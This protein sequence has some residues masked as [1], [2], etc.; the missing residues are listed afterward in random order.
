MP[1][2][3]S[4]LDRRKG[5]TVPEENDPSG[6]CAGFMVVGFLSF[7]TGVIVG[8]LVRMWDCLNPLL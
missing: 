8:Y 5:W 3:R 7:C 1:E 6:A 2:R 4:C